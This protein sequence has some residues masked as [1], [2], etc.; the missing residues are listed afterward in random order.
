[1][2]LTPVRQRKRNKRWLFFD[3]PSVEEL[4]GIPDEELAKRTLPKGFYLWFFAH[5]MRTI[6]AVLS[7]HVYLTRGVLDYLYDYLRW[8]PNKIHNKLF[9]CSSYNRE[10]QC[11]NGFLCRE[12]HCPFN[13]DT[14]ME[15]SIYNV[16]SNANGCPTST[17]RKE[18]SL[19]HPPNVLLWHSLHSRW[20]P[21]WAYPTLPRGATFR[22]AM[23]NNPNPVE[24][25]D[26]GR[27]FVTKVVREH[28][29]RFLRN[30]PPTVALQHCAN[31]SKNGVCCFGQNCQFV[32]VVSHTGE[33]AEKD[34]SVG[35]LSIKSAPGNANASIRPI[36]GQKGNST[37]FSESC[38]ETSRTSCPMMHFSL[39]SSPSTSVNAP[40]RAI[41]TKSVASDTSMLNTQLLLLSTPLIQT[42]QSP[43]SRENCQKQ[44]QLQ[45]SQPQLQP[46]KQGQLQPCLSTGCLP[47]FNPATAPFFLLQGPE[48]SQP[49]SLQQMYALPVPPQDGNA[50]GVSPLYFMPY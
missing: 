43:Q 12:V 36:P 35:D 41:S 23:P 9:I 8:G 42:G 47:Q 34:S 2:E 10:M 18:K 44:I 30:E 22:V 16:F 17:E 24:E 4:A 48:K 46:Q 28:Y 50:K 7:E 6:Y 25:F 27:I 20:T 13:T 32:H 14:A 49:I 5:H 15:A 38:G 31:Y 37:T 45:Q 11:S 29:E 1:M 26:S 21:P 3:V 33:R 39:S 19:K 40:P